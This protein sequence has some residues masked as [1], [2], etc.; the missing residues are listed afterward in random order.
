MMRFSP[1]RWV[2]TTGLRRNVVLVA[3]L[4]LLLALSTRWHV[5]GSGVRILSQSFAGGLQD[6]QDDSFGRSSGAAAV[7][8]RPFDSDPDPLLENESESSSSSSSLSSAP[9]PAAGPASIG[10]SDA[11]QALETLAMAYEEGRLSHLS[12]I[13]YDPSVAEERIHCPPGSL[14][15]NINEYISRLESFVGT[16]FAESPHRE[17][18]MGSLSRMVRVMPAVEGGD[19]DRVIYSFD[20]EG[21]EGTPP[22]FEGWKDRVK[23]WEVKVGDDEQVEKWF[24]ECTAGNSTSTAGEGLDTGLKGAVPGDSGGVAGLNHGHEQVGELDSGAE[25]PTPAASPWR[26]LWDGIDR[27][28]IKA[29]MLR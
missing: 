4:L 1:F 11:E 21:P 7:I 20:K 23:G 25:T 18:L 6:P 19:F 5:D 26:T 10:I 24:E 2:Y 3:G 9:D 8:Y 29:D 22:E 28:V 15:P 17:G 27:P 13:D 14:S 12:S 16:Y